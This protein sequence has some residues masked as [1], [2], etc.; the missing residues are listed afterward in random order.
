MR[1]PRWRMPI[2]TT[3]PNTPGRLTIV[4]RCRN[5]FLTRVRLLPADIRPWTFSR[6]RITPV[7]PRHRIRTRC[8]QLQQQAAPD[9]PRPERVSTRHRLRPISLHLAHERPDLP[10]R[11]RIS[12]PTNLARRA[13]LAHKP[14][15]SLARIRTPRDIR[16]RT[17]V[18][19]GVRFPGS[20]RSDRRRNFSQKSTR[21]LH[22][23]ELI[24]KVVSLV[25]SKH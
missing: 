10:S 16:N 14:T 3:G 20:P 5:I 4:A 23:A 18:L 12:V 25:L 7:Q 6:R 21:N 1:I 8:R 11:R 2:L 17:I 19:V 15:R 13:G 24:R 9:S 22:I